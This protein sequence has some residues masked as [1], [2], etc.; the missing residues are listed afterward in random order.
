MRD[1]TNGGDING[2]V[3]IV[4]KSS[5]NNYIPFEEMNVAQLHASLEHHKKLARK[6]RAN[7]DKACF[8]LFKF[9]LAIGVIL[10]IWYFFAGK[11]S[12][13]MFLI[14]LVG[15]GMPV[16]IAINTG[17][18]RSEFEQRQINTINYLI[19]LIRERQ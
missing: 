5:S 2:N 18:K 3:T 12:I 7:I 17:E 8:R 9:A 15:I 1:F 13:A 19:T 4:D 14:G 10:A 16:T 6:E 11:I